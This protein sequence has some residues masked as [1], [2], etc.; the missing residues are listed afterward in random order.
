MIFMRIFEHLSEDKDHVDVCEMKTFL[1][2]QRTRFLG[3]VKS[4]RYYNLIYMTFN[5]VLI[6]TL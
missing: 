6:V 5:V 3:L 1:E 2:L 4:Y